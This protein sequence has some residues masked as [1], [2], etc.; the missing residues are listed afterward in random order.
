M[1]ILKQLIILYLILL[2]PACAQDTPLIPIEKTPDWVLNKPVEIPADIP[3]KDIHNGIYYLTIDNQIKVDKDENTAFYSRYTEQ[4]VNQEGLEEVS[5]INLHYD[6]TYQSIQLHSL[7]IYRNGQQIDKTKTAKI[8]L[9]QRESGLEEQ[10]YNGYLTVNILIDDLR[11]GDVIDYSYT[12]IGANPVYKGI[13]NYDR[14]VQWSI[15]VHYQ[16]LRVLWGKSD[17]LNI[18]K[19]YTDV[20]VHEKKFGD[21]KEYSLAIKENRPYSFNSQTPKWFQPYGTVYLY[22]SEDWNDIAVW[23]SSLYENVL[24]GNGETRKIARQING[25][26]HTSEEKIS[27]A[28]NYVQSNIR[29]LGIEMGTNS[30]MPSAAKETLQRRYGDCKDKAVVFIAILK[31]LGIEAYP[32]LVNT[33]IK[34]HI[35]NLPPIV[36]AFDHVI[37]KVILGDKVYWLDPTREY[38]T[39][40]LENIYQP[41]YGYA[42]VVNK[43]TTDLESMN[44]PKQVYK[45]VIFDHFDLRQEAEHNITFE[46]Q[47][48]YIGYSAERQRSDVTTNGTTRLQNRYLNFYSTYYSDIQALMTFENKEDPVTGDITQKEKYLIKNFWSINS[49][50]REYTAT[51]YANAITSYFTQPDE[52]Q[53]NSPYLLTHPIDVEHTIQAQLGGKWKIT[54]DNV[55]I[56]NPYFNLHFTATFEK[57]TNLLTLVYHYRSKTDHVPANKID[58]YMAERNKALN[59]LEYGI[60]QYFN[61]PEATTVNNTTD[62]SEDIVTIIILLIALLYLAAFLYI[63]ISWRSDAKKEPEF[64]E[65]MF[66]PTSLVKLIALSIITF[67]IYL[68]YWFYRNY[69]YQK[70]RDN[71]SIMPIARGFF[72]NFWYYP[73]YATLA[74][75]SQ[76]RF[77]ENRVLI[78]PLAVLF[79]ILFF[80]SVA[81]S[82]RDGIMAMIAFLITPL[83]LIPLVNYINYINT[84]GSEA[85]MYHSRWR[86][87]HT[88]LALIS[89]PLIVLVSAEE[90]SLI[91]SDAVVKGEK[92]MQ[93]DI[94]F[95]HRKGMFPANEKLLYFYSDAFL[96]IRDD[97]NGFT[98][99]HVFSYW[100]EENKLYIEKAHFNTIQ[101]IDV[102]YS[103]GEFENTIVTIT[104][105]DNSNFSLYVSAIDALDK[106]FVK[107]L[108]N[109]W[110]MAKSDTSKQKL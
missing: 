53:R 91:P 46:S 19:L 75:D 56:D 6:P 40:S 38:Q 41:D 50:D 21:Y 26:A 81:L 31:A 109:R 86:L 69:L 36:D 59:L 47:T 30:H 15:P 105:K 73:L 108:Q 68:C 52:L 61:E 13:F 45:K 39:S 51:F 67:N 32:A 60:V 25:M 54:D 42:L 55:S 4:I 98:P 5:Q 102:N 43:E 37:V 20:P 9:L 92:V 72:Y 44:N 93:H 58:D 89:V 85:Y 96:M 74:E 3:V 14:C 10:L 65:A 95:M 76:K 80:I 63:F 16:Y 77:D 79:A 83:F 11:V 24:D 49:E 107:E 82:S 71:S 84:T 99:N 1:F 34:K 103:K 29:Y 8:K 12:R 104:R 17:Q 57:T 101:K 88:F 18:K 62:E 106:I 7:L 23:A 64:H 66:Y 78:K 87:R 97:G 94:R 35:S 33:E 27:A 28:L 110:E 90:L 22:E 48:K 100:K 70:D 2:V